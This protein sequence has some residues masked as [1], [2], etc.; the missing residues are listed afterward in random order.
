MSRGLRS[1]FLLKPRFSSAAALISYALKISK[2]RFSVVF[3]CCIILHPLNKEA[4]PIVQNCSASD[5]SLL[6]DL[7]LL[8]RFRFSHYNFLSSSFR[9]QLH[10]PLVSK[11]TFTNSFLWSKLIQ[12]HTIKKVHAIA[13]IKPSC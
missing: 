3:Q 5:S 4:F 13:S 1:N 2:G 7:P 11:N 9:L 6:V 12:F 8:R 10:R